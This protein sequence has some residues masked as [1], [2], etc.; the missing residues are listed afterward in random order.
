M[1]GVVESDMG[2]G[3]RDVRRGLRR[4]GE[5]DVLDWERGCF[6]VVVL[7]LCNKM[8]ICVM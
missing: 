1:W 7:G 5:R 4:R 6:I 2:W 3:D 8:M